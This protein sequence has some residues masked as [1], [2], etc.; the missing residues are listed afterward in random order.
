MNYIN[1]K[2]CHRLTRLGMTTQKGITH[3]LTCCLFIFSTYSLQLN[4]QTASCVADFDVELGASGTTTI[5]TSDLDMGS[6]G[7]GFSY[8]N[9]AGITSVD[10]TCSD[11]G[12]PVTL[13]LIISTTPDADPGTFAECEVVV[14]VTDMTNPVASCVSSHGPVVVGDMVAAADLDNVMTPSSDACSGV[15]VI[16]IVDGDYTFTCEDADNGSVTLTLRVTDSATNT[17]ECDVTITVTDDVAPIPSCADFSYNLSDGPSIDVSLISELSFTDNCADN[18]TETVSPN[19]VACPHDGTFMITYTVSDRDNNASCTATV[20]VVDDV[21]PEIMCNQ[22]FTVSLDGTGNATITVAD[23]V[24]SS[25]DNCTGETVA[26]DINSFDCMMIGVNTVTA[27]V[28]D[29]ANL[30]STCMVTV[31]VEDGAA[32]PPVAVCKDITIDL[33]AAGNA[34]ILPQDVNDGSGDN[35]TVNLES[36]VPFQFDCTNVGS[37]LVVLTVSDNT[38]S[39]TCNATVTVEDNVLPEVACQDITVTLSGADNTYTITVADIDNGSNDIC[40][41]TLE[42]DIT[43]VDCNSANPTTVTLQAT[44]SNM[45]VSTCIA[46]VSIMQN[47]TGPTAMCVAPGTITWDLNDPVTLTPADFNDGSTGDCNLAINNF[48][49]NSFSCSDLDIDSPSGTVDITLVVTDGTLSTSTCMTDVQITNNVAP[50]ANCV[51]GPVDVDIV[52]GTATIAVA[53]IDSGSEVQYDGSTATTYCGTL[54][55]ALDITTVDCTNVG[56]PIEVTLTA[57]EPLSGSTDDCVV[58]INVRDVTAPTAVCQDITVDLTTG[59]TIIGPSLIDNGSSDECNSISLSLDNTR[60]DCA[61]MPTS[62]VTLTATDIGGNTDQCTATVTIED[63]TAPTALC[64]DITVNLDNMGSYTLSAEELDDGSNDEF[65]SGGSDSGSITLDLVPTASSWGDFDTG[66]V[67]LNTVTTTTIPADAVITD[68]SIDV[69]LNHSWLGDLEIELTGPDMGTVL[70]MT[71]NNSGSQRCDNN[72]DNINTTFDDVSGLPVICT[73]VEDVII[74]EDC[75]EVQTIAAISGTVQTHDFENGG[76]GLNQWIGMLAAGGWRVRINDK[77][78][79]DGG[80]LQVFD[81][82][83]EYEFDGGSGPSSII[84]NCTA[85]EELTFSFASGQT[86]F[87]CSALP[88]N[89]GAG[90]FTVVVDVTD[91][92]GNSSSCTQTVTVLDDEIPTVT[93]TDVTVELGTDGTH[94]I[95]EGDV[96]TMFA[97]NCEIEEFT[98]NGNAVLTYDCDDIVA[99][100]GAGTFPVVVVAIDE[101]MNS[102]VSCTSMV[103]VIDNTAPTVVCKDITVNTGG[104]V[105]AQALLDTYVDNC[106]NTPE[107]SSFDMAFTMGME[108]LS[109]SCTDVGTTNYTVY[110]SDASGNVSS[111]SG[112]I[113]RVDNAGPMPNCFDV[114]IDLDASG[115]ASITWPDISSI[116]DQ[117]L[118]NDVAA[119]SLSQLTFDCTMT[120][121]NPVIVTVVDSNGNSNSCTSTVTIEDNEDPVIDLA[122]CPVLDPVNPFVITLSPDGTGILDANNLGISTSDNCGVNLLLWYDGATPFAATENNQCAD[123]FGILD[124]DL[125]SGPDV[126][127]LPISCDDVGLHLINLFAIDDSG[128]AGTSLSLSTCSTR[129]F[130]NTCS[131]IVRIDDGAAPTALCQDISVALDDT[132]NISVPG[133]SVNNGSTDDCDMLP[134]LSLSQTNF[135]CTE[136]GPQAV[137]LT[138]TDLTG[139]SSTCDAIVTISDM[140]A[141]VAICNDVLVELDGA[142]MGS[143]TAEDFDVMGLSSDAC[144][145]LAPTTDLVSTNFTC[146]DITMMPIMVTLTVTDVNNNTSTDVCMLSI[147]DNE[148][149]IPVCTPLTV[150]LVYDEMTSLSSV[151]VADNA[152]VGM[153]TDNCGIASAVSSMTTYTCSDIGTNDVLLTVTDDSGNIATQD[154]EVIVEGPA[155]IAICQDITIDLDTDGMASIA[156]DAVDNGSFDDCNTSVT[157]INTG[158]NYIDEYDTDINDFTC[159][160]LGANTVVLTV[161]D[162]DDNTAT[163]EATVTV[164]DIIAPVPVCKTDIEVQLDAMTG[165]YTLTPGELDDP[166][167]TIENC[168]YT[169]TISITDLDCNSGSMITVDL[170]A[171]DDSNNSN[172]VSCNVTIL[173]P[174]P[175]AQCV[176]TF[177]VELDVNGEATITVADINDGSFDICENSTT[178]AL[179]VSSLSYALTVDDDDDDNT[180]ITCASGSTA[181]VTLT[182]TDGS[183]NSDDCTVTVTIKDAPPV[184]MCND[185][186]VE[187]DIAGNYMITPADLAAIGAGTTD[188]CGETAFTYSLSQG[189]GMGGT[190]SVTSLDCTQLGTDHYTFTVEDASGNTSVCTA[191]ITVEDNLAPDM[192]CQPTYT[193]TLDA[194]GTFV[195][196]TTSDIDAGSMDNCDGSAFTI[197]FAPGTPTSFDCTNDG[198]SYSIQLNGTD[199]QGN[200]GICNS[201]ITVQIDPAAPCSCTEDNI[202]INDIPLVDGFRYAN[203]QITSEGQVPVNGDVHFRAGDNVELL[204]GF[205]VILG[206]EFLGDTGPCDQ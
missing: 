76:M 70:L 200:L 61:D 130:A 86:S 24:D 106:N 182:V 149:P 12:T 203:I 63:N 113:T 141:P 159:M 68:I 32:T 50:V 33:D 37:N 199:S 170:T 8:I 46:N 44:D 16:E 195:G 192:N 48:S 107:A 7:G 28:T 144:G 109:F 126:V 120:G 164:R 162:A 79:F 172:T 123:D 2:N 205:E 151:T 15:G 23:V 146:S 35:C 180:S 179:A 184:A 10:I 71:N 18:V 175:V 163:C 139:L 6:T 167:A 105:A 117:S 104:D 84:D 21:G 204:P 191:G 202:A 19:M 85:P 112:D 125:V 127:T 174:A 147:E 115:N 97:D 135:D 183:M 193:V 91:E 75:S 156:E 198:L 181:D 52:A 108:L 74:H 54:A 49:P 73:I 78:T 45:N 102:S 133:T 95:S 34:T 171:T 124:N 22:D 98:Y 161:T 196:L 176:S 169:P 17:D 119:I 88:V 82:N 152:V 31:T 177:E 51:T 14:T 59:V 148:N 87:D 110:F 189:D 39:A 185:I 58:T 142:G 121:D 30:T 129:L 1:L 157:L 92:S 66:D 77:F 96:T 57:T 89:G 168:N 99:N 56:K 186:T 38:T 101:S 47:M 64:Q 155:P 178:T 11:F 5:T 27:T 60:F 93:C 122:T 53:D 4:A 128:N 40:G 143:V 134:T 114:D 150:Q 187:L 29:A 154:C 62:T 13:T 158:S 131:V 201:I 20:T 136:I 42:I 81:L 83:I 55:L 140:T 90:T 67:I 100:G 69:E 166:D 65:M 160:N 188:A 80:C 132:G 26:L 118:C 194:A 72:T 3:V 111:C 153:S 36:V 9:T 43:E 138:V 116:P 41:V 173:D 206:G 165:T 103:T 137:V 145:L 94:T 25:S 190:V 197:E